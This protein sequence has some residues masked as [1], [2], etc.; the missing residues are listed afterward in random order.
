MTTATP[1]DMLQLPLARDES[2]VIRVGGTRVTL[3]L[4]VEYHRQGFSAE[5]IA[6]KF[7]TLQ[8]SD[9]YAAIAFYLANSDAVDREIEIGKLQ[10]DEW[11]AKLAPYAP[12]EER[13]ERLLTNRPP[14]SST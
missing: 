13:I 11:R 5:S 12:A 8:L 7:S 6:S 4:I 3:D 9:V 2:G 14:N 10:A 1:V